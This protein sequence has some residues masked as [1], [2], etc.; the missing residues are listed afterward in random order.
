MTKKT[1]VSQKKNAV[2]AA[3]FLLPPL[4]LFLMWLFAGSGYGDLSE[5]QMVDNY[6]SYFPSTIQNA[7]II[8]IISVIFC[9]LAIVFSSKNFKREKLALRISMLVV[10]LAAIFILLFDIYHLLHQ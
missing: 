5:S 10:C 6:L 1:H 4:I 3:L 7:K 8:F 9:L 2:I